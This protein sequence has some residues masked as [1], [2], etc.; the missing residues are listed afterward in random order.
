MTL[1]PTR[2]AIEAH[3]DEAD[4]K[5]NGQITA[6]VSRFTLRQ[7]LQE[8]DAQ[9]EGAT[10]SL[11]SALE[12]IKQHDARVKVLEDALLWVKSNLHLHAHPVNVYAVVAKALTQTG[13]VK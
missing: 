8:H 13:E 6:T 3:I 2:L 12:V 4:G 10:D 11:A 9:L 7:F 5:I 1:T